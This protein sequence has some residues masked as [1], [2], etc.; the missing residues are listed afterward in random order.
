MPSRGW[1]GGSDDEEARVF[2]EQEGEMLHE[3]VAEALGEEEVGG[4]G[5]L[6]D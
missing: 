1:G 4:G 6:A 2:L 3:E 5:L